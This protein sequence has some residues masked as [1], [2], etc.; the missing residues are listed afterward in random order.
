MAK[1]L[2]SNIKFV[3]LQKSTPKTP[4]YQFRIYT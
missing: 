1:A 2:V 3:P 4:Q